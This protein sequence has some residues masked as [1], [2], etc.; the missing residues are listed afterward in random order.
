MNRRRMPSRKGW[1][2]NLQCDDGYYCYRNPLT[3][4]KKGL[5]R[6]KS[7]AFSEARAA[8]KALAEMSKS[9]LAQWVIG[10]EAMTLAKWLPIYEQLWIERRSPADSTLESARRYFKRFAETDFAKLPMDKITTVQVSKYLDTLEEESGS[11]AAVN[12][13]ARLLDVFS[14]AITKGHI[15]PGRN[16]AEATIPANYE[17]KRDRL[18]LE[19]F[20]KMHEKAEG[21]LAN[22]MILALLTGQRVSDI[23]EMKFSSVSGDFLHVEPIKLRGAVRLKLETK[24]RLDAVGMSLGDA[25]KQCRDMIVSQYLIHQTRTSGTYKAGEKVSSEGISAAFSTLRDTVGIKAADGKTPPT[26]HEIR[27]LSERLYRKQ[28]GKEFA[29]ALLGHKSET[30]TAKYDDTRGSEWQVVTAV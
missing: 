9:S 24:I 19:Q 10:G 13:R 15:E 5:G 12:M 21:W 29:Q 2:N 27:S 25:I 28:Y 20:L 23:S 8:N 3:G 22:A 17:A 6:D 1:P 26:F 14:Y 18:S 7:H 4:K 11:G 30:M 16:P